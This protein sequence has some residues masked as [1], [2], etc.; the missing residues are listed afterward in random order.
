MLV[1][2]LERVSKTDIPTTSIG[3]PESDVFDAGCQD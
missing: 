1:S 2:E 3:L